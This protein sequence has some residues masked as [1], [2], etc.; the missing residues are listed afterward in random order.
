MKIKNRV[1]I[2]C[3]LVTFFQQAYFSV[4]FMYPVM[5]RQQGH[6]FSTIGWLLS[7][8][9]IAATATRPLA[10]VL[11]ERYGF[12]NTII[13]S[14]AAMLITAMPL[15]FLIDSSLIMLTRL[16]MGVS[17]SISMIAVSSYQSLAVPVETRGRLFGWIA[18]AY[19]LP[20]VLLL[21]VWEYQI[22]HGHFISYLAFPPLLAILAGAVSFFLPKISRTDREK[23]RARSADGQWGSWRELFALPPFWVLQLTAFLFAFLN[24]AALQ[25]TPALLNTMGLSASFFMVSNASMA[26]ALRVF[27]SQL[28]DRINRKAAIGFAI[29]VMGLGLQAVLMSGSNC[30]L[31]F[32]GFFYG[33]GMGFGFPM[34]LA[35]MPD[36]VPP[37][38]RPKG[39]SVTFL[40]MD[41]G[42][43]LAPVVIGYGSEFLRLDSMMHIF[44]W[45]AA[46]SGPLLYFV[47]WRRII[48]GSKV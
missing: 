14:A 6:P 29:M 34:I 19:V 1:F 15:L 5:L 16:L 24:S 21:P 35:L 8:F 18:T 42:F 4:F 41:I 27:T 28:L 2:L 40:A 25:Y 23:A 11:T 48:R 7:I 36:V 45:F 12:R 9:S 13:A 46:A 20:Q 31:I 10:G 44:G 47:F 39:I 38:L 37:G 33:I 30:A 3:L 32:G 43:I 22:A 17:F 26:I